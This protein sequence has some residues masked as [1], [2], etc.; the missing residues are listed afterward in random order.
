MRREEALLGDIVAESDIV[1]TRTEHCDFTEFLT[2]PILSRGILHSLMIIGE[3]ANRIP[4]D[5]RLRYPDVPWQDLAG[6]RHRIVHD[7][8]GVDLRLVWTLITTRLPR[9]RQQV[10][11]ILE[12]D[13]TE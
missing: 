9:L 4:I 1:L 11:Q 10:N 8:P 7:Y 13:Y 3:A 6:L 2:D 5:V 12:A